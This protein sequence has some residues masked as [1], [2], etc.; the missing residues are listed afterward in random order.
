MPGKV[1]KVVHTQQRC[2]EQDH[3]YHRSN[4]PKKKAKESDRTTISERKVVHN[5]E[6][7]CE[8]VIIEVTLPRK[9]QKSNVFFLK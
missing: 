2:C 7:C 3:C 5:G 9:N 8:Q 6:R 1:T 4:S